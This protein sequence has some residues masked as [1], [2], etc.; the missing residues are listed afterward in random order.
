MPSTIPIYRDHDETYRAD[1]CRPLVEAARLNSLRLV[2]L[3]HGHYPGKV[4][5]DHAMPGIKM[6]GFWDASE[7]QTWG[8]PWH[9]NEGLELSFLES[10]S[11]DYSVDGRDYRLRPDDLAIARPW[12]RHRVGNPNINASR[13]HWIILDVGV[14]RPDQAWKWPPWF[15][16]SKTDADELTSLLRHS[17]QSVYRTV[18][19]IRECFLKLSSAIET[20]QEGSNISRLAITVNDLFLKLLDGLRQKKIKLDE[21]LSTTRRTVTLFLRDLANNPGNLSIDWTVEDMASNCGLHKTQF[22][23]HVRCLTNVSPLQFLNRCRLDYAAQMLQSNTD[24]SVTEVAL[25]AGFNSSQYFATVFT[26]RFGCS[27]SVFKAQ[28]SHLGNQ[29]DGSA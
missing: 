27:P 6:V 29:Q 19:G 16:L 15:L 9:F 13:L 3:C 28:G 26:H 17:E 22:T 18:P 2:A 14:R 23:H 11:Q 4:L 21:S 20:D 5:P 7:C 8:L 25:D 12:Q 10:G 1:S 24:I